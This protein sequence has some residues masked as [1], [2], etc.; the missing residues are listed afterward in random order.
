MSKKTPSS[1]IVRN[2]QP[3]DVPQ[4]IEL[5][6]R[7]YPNGVPWGED[8][9]SSHLR[10]FPEG[11]IVA[12]DTQT[13]QVV[14]MAASLAVLWD[15]YDLNTNWRDFTDS[16]YF[17]NH[18]PQGHT[19]YAAE[20]MVDPTMQG[21]GIGKK[22]YATRRD[23]CRALNLRRIRAGARLRGY[24]KYADQMPP[25]EYVK[26]IITKEIGDPT[27]S[28]QIKQGFRVLGV[29]RDYLQHDPASHGHAAIIEW[30]NHQA[31]TRRDYTGRDP[32]FAKPRKKRTDPPTPD[33]A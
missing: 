21:R 30:I 32:R 19:L 24:G 20:V 27:L 18:D 5:C 2:T 31:A 33:P 25:E 13:N 7:V 14:G 22:I 17:K 6:R 4:I 9:L 15:D 10:M 3:Q 12:V 26:K 23:I 1:I 28:F 16:G 11:Q 8:Q 29:V